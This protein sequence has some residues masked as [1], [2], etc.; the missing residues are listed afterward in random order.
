MIL[1][2]ILW[3]FFFQKLQEEM[4]ILSIM[5]GYVIMIQ[6]YGR[7][8]NLTL[9][10]KSES[11]QQIHQKH[12]ATYVSI[13]FMLFW[14]T[15][16]LSEVS[17]MFILLRLSKGTLFGYHM[18][19]KRTSRFLFTGFCSGK[20]HN[21]INSVIYFLQ[22]PHVLQNVSKMKLRAT[23]VGEVDLVNARNVSNAYNIY[24]HVL[25]WCFYILWNNKESFHSINYP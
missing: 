25:I 4:Y 2:K 3:F 23:I 12:Q 24:I 10:T 20:Y 8:S 18:R 1:K 13:I 14:L 16:H 17:W 19:I 22:A 7:T 5:I 9:N 15:L 6:F 11:L 21:C